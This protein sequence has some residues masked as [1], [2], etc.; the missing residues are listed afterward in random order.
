MGIYVV[1]ATA[2]IFG[3]GRITPESYLGLVTMHGTF[4]VLVGRT[5]GRQNAF[6]NFFLPLQIG[7]NRMAFPGLNMAAFWLAFVSFLIMLTAFF[8]Q[9]GAPISGWT[10]YAPLS[11]IASAGPGQ[12]LGL[13]LWL[14]SI[15]IF[16]I[17]SGIAAV[18]FIVTTIKLRAPGMTWMRLPLPCWAWFVTAFL[19]LS[20]FSVLLA[21][22]VMLFLEPQYVT[23]LFEPSG[24]MIRGHIIQHQGAAPVLLQDLL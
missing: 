16:C 6:G 9:G 8:A 14:I 11:A 7:A 12:G 20:A 1:W 4:M 15:A 5:W 18:N 24:V 2:I 19:I 17:A 22:A 21:A 10:H 13:D 3:I 23:K